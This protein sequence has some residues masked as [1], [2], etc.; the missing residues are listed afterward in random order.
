[1]RCVEPGCW[2]GNAGGWRDYAVQAGIYAF[3][4]GVLL[5]GM[6]GAGQ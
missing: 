1:M 2:C 3:I 4:A 6:Q 5:A